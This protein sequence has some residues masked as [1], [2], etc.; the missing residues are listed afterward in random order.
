MWFAK[1]VWSSAGQIPPL[2]GSEIKTVIHSH[3]VPR[4]GGLRYV[5]PR[6][7]SC[8]PCGHS[9]AAR[10]CPS[11]LFTGILKLMVRGTCEAEE[12][13]SLK[14]RK[15]EASNSPPERLSSPMH[16]SRIVLLFPDL[17][18]GPLHGPYLSLPKCRLPAIFISLLLFWKENSRLRETS[19]QKAREEN[20]FSYSFEHLFF[21]GDIYIWFM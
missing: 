9:H 11:G 12:T 4:L 10:P 14:T 5:L 21:Y 8:C 2:P 6:N 13:T 19:N 20:T 18:R 16:V 3:S 7:C 17:G 15:R 1:L